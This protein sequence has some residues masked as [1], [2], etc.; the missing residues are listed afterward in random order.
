MQPSG[1]VTEGTLVDAFEAEFAMHV[2]GRRCLAV[3]AASSGMRLALQA[4]GIGRGDEVVTVS[5]GP[6]GAV[7]SIQ[8]T[9]AVAVFADIDAQTFC[10]D[11]MAAA[12][13]IGPRTAA[14]V[15]GHRF[16]HPAA[17]DALQRLA[18]RHGIALLEDA[19]E[20]LGAELDGRPA[21]TFGTAAVFPHCVVTGS[22]ELAQALRRTRGADARPSEETAAEQCTA[23][24]WLSEHT[25][26][27]RAH[28]R[29]LDSALTGVAAPYVRPGARHT[30]HRYTVRVPGNG[31]P[32]RDAFARALIARGVPAAVPIATPVH[33]QPEYR[34]GADLPRTEQAAA[35]TLALPVNPDHTVRDIEQIAAACNAL[36]GLL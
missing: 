27:R 13:A 9:G 16:G 29:A 12:A 19:G 35:Q 20:A 36:G 32:D 17:M 23:V 4:L 14:I 5:Y 22:T 33:R 8:R 11:P 26:R 2:G 31:R 7:Q 10:L 34:S 1:P 21:G 30:Y 18:E 24:R 25:T 28:A 15:A 3:D 6:V